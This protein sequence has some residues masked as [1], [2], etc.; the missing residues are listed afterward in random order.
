MR[1]EVTAKLAPVA[2]GLVVFAVL[3]SYVASE[4]PQ[5]SNDARSLLREAGALVPNIDK[6]QQPSVAAN[7]SG[8][9]LRADDLAG[10]ILTVQAVQ[11][12]SGRAFAAGNIASMLAWRG[13]LPLSLELIRN[14][15]EGNDWQKAQDYVSVTRQLA[16]K[17]D[18]DA[19]LRIAGMIQECNP[20]DGRTKLFVDALMQVY[21]GQ[22]KA[23]DEGGAM[24]TLNMAI[25][26][27]ESQKDVDTTL[28]TS[29]MIYSVIATELARAGNRGAAFTLMERFYGMVASSGSPQDRQDVLFFLA[30]TQASVGELDAA[31]HTAEQLNPGGQRDGV[32]AVVAMQG[33]NQGDMQAI[34]DLTSLPPSDFRDANLQG[35]SSSFYEFGNYTRAL[36]IIDLLPDSSE[37]ASALASLAYQQAKKEDPITVQTLELA[38][39]AAE[40]AGS[41]A[42]PHVF[43]FIAVTT[44]MLGD[45]A[46][47]EEIISR[48]ND[49]DRWWAAESVSAMLVLADRK[50]E[51]VSLAHS[52]SAAY[53]KAT[54]LLGVATALIEQQREAS[55]KTADATE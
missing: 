8:Q 29:A 49:E 53:P 39:E 47:A 44:A 30:T 6:V 40:A 32:V 5:T 24:D 14:S 16:S 21:G 10:A 31:L 42:K 50:T 46:G 18:F 38:K 43:G 34:D 3:P 1:L 26:A 28:S 9:Q 4:D 51:A 48:M 35:A 22:W 11:S 13:N 15:A 41:A 33:M 17:G 54:A 12:G 19:A 52:Q 25:K 45:F 7:I 27:V 36:A 37:P 20:F 23:K 2:L 55:R